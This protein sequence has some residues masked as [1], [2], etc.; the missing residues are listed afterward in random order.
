MTPWLLDTGPLVAFFDRS[1]SFHPW[2][3][4]Q[5]AD[6]PIPLLTCEAVLAEAAYLLAEHGGLPTERVLA[7]VERGVV[8]TPFRIQEHVGPVARLLEK[9]RDQGMQLADACIVRMSEL[10]RDCRVF[11][12][13]RGAF[14]VYRRFGRQIIPL[15]APP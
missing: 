8:A 10:H 9:Y 6:A 13:D 1:D 7:L 3:V 15:V 12:V 5:W 4:A 11:T 2:A 14:K